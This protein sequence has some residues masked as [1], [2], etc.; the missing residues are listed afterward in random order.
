M[1]VHVGG[2]GTLLVI[3]QLCVLVIIKEEEVSCYQKRL[4]A[5]FSLIIFGHTETLMDS[6]W[7]TTELAWTT[8]PES[9][10]S[11]CL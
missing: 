1:H 10:V 5:D 8:Y 2:G 7:A 3:K 11:K 9:G 4:L 6:K